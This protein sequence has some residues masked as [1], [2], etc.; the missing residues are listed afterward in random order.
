MIVLLL[1]MIILGILMLG[2]FATALIMFVNGTTIQLV[3][4]LLL[5]IFLDFIEELYLHI[6]TFR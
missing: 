1:V 3:T 2:Y 6:K 4:P 5:I